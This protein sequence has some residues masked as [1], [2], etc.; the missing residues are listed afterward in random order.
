MERAMMRQGWSLALVGGLL[1]VSQVQARAD[2][3]KGMEIGTKIDKAWAGYKSEE[4]DIELELIS[5]NGQS[6]T[7]KMHGKGRE[8]ASGDEQ[9]IMTIIWPADLKG[10]RLL[11][12]NH[13]GKD[14]D[15]W[16]YLPS[17]ER[18]KRISASG[19]SGSFMGSEFAFEDLVN[20]WWV[21]KFKYDYLR[22]QKVGSRDTWVVERTPR[23]KDSGY[24]KEIAWIDKE[25]L[26]ALRIDFYDRKGKLLK[27]ADFK[28]FKKYGNKWRP[29]R[30]EMTNR[31]TG[32]KSNVI[33]TSRAMGKSFSDQDFSPDAMA[34]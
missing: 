2:E 16:L 34:D 1:S 31:Q 17:I 21:E 26:S 12:W 32:K 30:V 18:V 11:T 22:D 25:Y 29:D 8:I 28:Q 3:K 14:D 10:T 6:V 23:D 9:S 5:G 20:A 13:R 27:T 15:Q 4:N 7:R 33:W 19:R 24:S